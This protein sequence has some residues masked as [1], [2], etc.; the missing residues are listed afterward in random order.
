MEGV[1]RQNSGNYN[2]PTGL[3]Y[4]TIPIGIDRD[5]YIQTCYRKERVA[6]QLDGGGSVI[7]NCYISRSTLQEIIFPDEINQ[8]GSCVAF[9]CLKHH[10]LPIIVAV[11]SKPD[12]TQLLEEKAFKKSVATKEANVSIEGK[13]KSGELF[14]NVES[15]SENEGSIYITL[16]SKNNT[17][18]F[19][20]K[21]FGEVNIYSEGKTTLKALKN[22]NLQKIRIEDQEE[23]ISSE[24]IL[25]DDGFEIRDSFNNTINS[26]SDG[27]INVFPSLRCNLFE[28]SEPLPKGD[29]L[30]T[31]LEKMKNRI[32]IIIN[33]LDGATAASAT[34]SAYALF[35]KAG[36][37]A[38]TEVEDFDDM[39]SDKSFTD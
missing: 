30:K 34:A 28:G 25:S 13:G 12:E 36:L 10:N 6:I 20:L 38:I 26:D 15:N 33:T 14:I 8:L 4:I 7:N 32:D 19:E 2:Y 22:V 39:N 37:A 3:G 5:L 23:I 29:T 16:K 31:E 27:A 1:S 35:V 11:V 24:V 18:K 21:C 9:I 17:S